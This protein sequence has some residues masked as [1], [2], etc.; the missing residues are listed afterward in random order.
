[1][2]RIPRVACDQEELGGIDTELILDMGVDL[3]CG[4]M[5]FDSVRAE[6]SLEQIDDSAM[7]E[8]PGL[9]LRRV[10]RKGEQPKARIP[11]PAE[12]CGNFRMRRHGGELLRQFLPV[13]FA[14]PD[15]TGIREHLH[16]S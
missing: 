3:G 16:D 6:S 11:E 4:L 8:L 7:L 2:E 9:R 13:R 10:V 14:D 15:A 1:T 5:A 12:R